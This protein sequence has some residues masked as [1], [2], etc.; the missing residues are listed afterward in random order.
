MEHGWG[1]LVRVEVRMETVFANLINL[2]GKPVGI[3]PKPVCTTSAPQ[4]NRIGLTDSL[5]Q[6][7]CG[8]TNSLITDSLIQSQVGQP[9]LRNPTGLD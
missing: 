7:R 8:L 6:S 2:R 4:L 1:A 3:N 9:Q 5:I